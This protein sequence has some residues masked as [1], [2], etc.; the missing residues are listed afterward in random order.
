MLSLYDELGGLALYIY[1]SLV[2][3]RGVYIDNEE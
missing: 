2:S 1:L 3:L